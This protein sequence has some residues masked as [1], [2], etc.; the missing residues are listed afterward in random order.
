[1]MTTVAFFYLYIILRQLPKQ[2]PFF[3][4]HFFPQ[5]WDAFDIMLD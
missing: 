4:D 1:M 2:I 3:K 5:P